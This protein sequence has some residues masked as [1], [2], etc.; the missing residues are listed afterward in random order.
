MK[1]SSN[2]R[3]KVVSLAVNDSQALLLGG[4]L[5]NYALWFEPKTGNFVTS[6]QYGREL[7]TWVKA[8]NDTTPDE[9]Y[10]AKPCNRL[11]PRTQYGI[12]TR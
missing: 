11:L 2:G 9:R 4:R 12:S 6:S 10:S 5:A 8:F 3:S 7:P 1:L